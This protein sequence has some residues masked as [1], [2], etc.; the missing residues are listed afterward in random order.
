MMK[1]GSS[2]ASQRIALLPA[3]T[4]ARANGQHMCHVPP[5]HAKLVDTCAMAMPT[6]MSTLPQAPA[7]TGLRGERAST[8]GMGRGM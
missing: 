3:R 2:G 7:Q 4:L 8:G 5:C 6:A 1:R